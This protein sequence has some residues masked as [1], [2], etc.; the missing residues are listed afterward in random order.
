MTNRIKNIFKFNRATQGLS[1]VEVLAAM[2]IFSVLSVSIITLFTTS[3]NTQSSIL[4]NQQLLNESG[5]VVEYMHKA[6]RM[7]ARDNASVGGTGDCAGLEANYLINAGQDEIVFLG[8]DNVVDDYVCMKFKLET[9]K[10]KVYK[11]SDSNSDNFDAGQEL[12]S[13]QVLVDVLKFDIS[14]QT[15]GTDQPKVT[16]MIHMKANSKRVSPIPEIIIQ[17]TASQRN[18]NV[19]ITP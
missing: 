12:T 17:T 2:A 10:I 9:G 15:P 8:Y 1:L 3:I 13:S 4:Q 18:L 16:V 14:G 5:H 11:S 19:D 7:A 6:I